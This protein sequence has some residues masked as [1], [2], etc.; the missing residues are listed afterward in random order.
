MGAKAERLAAKPTVGRLE[1][2]DIAKRQRFVTYGTVLLGMLVA[3]LNQTVI[4][5]AMP[6]IATDLNGLD[7]YS[8]VFTS[9]MVTS[10]VSLPIFGKLSDMYGR[11]QFFIGGIAILTMA[12]ALCGLS[13]N[14]AE[15]TIFRGIQGVGGGMM[16]AVSI[17]TVGDLFTPMERGKWQAFNQGVWSLGSIVGPVVGGLVTDH[18]SWRWVFYVNIPVGLVAMAVA[19][20]VMPQLKHQTGWR[21]VDYLGASVLLLV[22][23]PLLVAFSFAGVRYAWGSSQVLGLLAF[24]AVMLAV[25]WLVESHAQEPIISPRLFTNPIFAI[26]GFAG[27]MAGSAFFG[28]PIYLP[29]LVQ[30]VMGQSATG[31]GVILMPM[32]IGSFVGSVIGGQV[33]SR[34][35]RYRLLVV[36][37][38]AV[39]TVGMFLLSRTGPQTSSGIVTLEM[40]LLGLGTGAAIPIFMVAVQNAF[41][42]QMVGTVLSSSAFLRSLGGAVGEAIMGT[43]AVSRFSAVFP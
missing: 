33:L 36:C 26:M 11:K 38:M 9:Y 12:S 39:G 41:P 20:I 15:L 1:S 2:T 34:W 27:F 5:T 42:Q 37:S 43:L 32:M 35:G 28:A 31:S 7:N 17:A 10:S 29:L 24:S 4:S 14:M 23:A 19:I 30:A 25:F 6:R 22:V 16:I 13:R 8:W 18:L 3:A 40:V 21:K